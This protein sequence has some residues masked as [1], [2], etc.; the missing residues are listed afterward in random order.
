MCLRYPGVSC[1]WNYT[2]VSRRRFRFPPVPTG[3]IIREDGTVLNYSK[4]LFPGLPIALICA[5]PF[6]ITSSSA[7]FAQEASKLHG[8]FNISTD[9]ELVLLDVSVKDAKGGYVSDLQKDNFT[10]EE[11]GVPQKITSFLSKDVPVEAGLVFDASGSMRTKRDEVNVAGLAFVNASNPQDQIF[12]MDFNDEVRSALPDDV[13]FTDKIDLLRVAL[14]KHPTEGRTVL[15]DAIAASL[16]H[17]ELG[18]REKKT[19]V[20]VSD[21]GDT[22]SKLSLAETMH[23]IEKSH[24]TIYTVGIFEDDDP[25]RNPGV[26]KH[27]A[28]VS[29]GE[30]F[31]LR[32]VSEVI[33]TSRKIAKDIRSRYTIG[34]IPEHKANGSK[35]GLRRLRVTANAPDRGKLIVRTRTSYMDLHR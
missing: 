23:E 5:A 1:E 4:A 24:A 2:P 12:V 31:I 29:G 14:S 22:A 3:A 21:G 30:C 28:Q 9:V 17:L 19:L 33:P 25:D 6:F 8:D 20:V 27:I 13:P 34:Y 32:N 7:S 15:Y 35:T 16:K 18:N 26:L 10:I 11:D